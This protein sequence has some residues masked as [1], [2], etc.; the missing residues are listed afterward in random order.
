MQPIP[1]VHELFMHVWRL[2]HIGYTAVPNAISPERLEPIRERFDALIADYENV[3]SA[4]VDGAS[5]SV[6]GVGSIDL[7]RFF[8]LDPLFEDFMDLPAVLPIVQAARNHDVVLLS[9]GMGN[10][11]A[12]NTPAATL[13]HRDGGPYLRLTIYLDDVTEE[14]GPD[15]GGPRQPQGPES[16]ARH[17]PTMTT[18][19][20][21]CRAWCRSPRR[22]APASSTTP[23]SGTPPC[24]IA[25]HARAGWCGW[26]TSGPPRSTT[27]A[28]SGTTPRNS[29]PA[30]PTPCGAR[31][32]GARTEDSGVGAGL[33]PA[34]AKDHCE[35]RPSFP[36]R[37]ESTLHVTR[38][39]TGFSWSFCAR[40]SL[41]GYPN[42][43]GCLGSVGAGFKPALEGPPARDLES[44]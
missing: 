13:W 35:T 26:S 11:R 36:R 28:P 4:V 21:R 12:P 25:R 22:R 42:W 23:T 29:S 34:P 19:R 5:T 20:G 38:W 40:S 41:A 39:R 43:G 8:E 2:E 14:V 44:L 9:S 24:P 27:C 3:P 1:S 31:C 15:G 18:N 37:R 6:K 16:S 17:G 30:R 7:H 33:K 10:Y 32:W